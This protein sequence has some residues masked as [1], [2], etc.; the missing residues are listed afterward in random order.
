MA[1]VLA[2]GKLMAG[3]LAEL[4]ARFPG[5]RL[6][7]DRTGAVLQSSDGARLLLAL[8][9]MLEAALFAGCVVGALLAARRLR[10]AEG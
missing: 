1:I 7:I 5:S 4:A 9:T 3:S 10:G 8:A 2:G 6:G